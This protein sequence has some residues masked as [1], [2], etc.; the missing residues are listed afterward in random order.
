MAISRK[1][2]TKEQALSRLTSL[3]GRSEQC[4]YEVIK[5]MKG[6]GL[7]PTHIK[8]VLDYLKENRF[9]DDVRYARS[10]I[11]DKARFSSWGPYKIK[12]EL[13]KRRIPSKIIDPALKEVDPS[14]WKEAVLKCGRNKSRS[15]DLRGEEGYEN[16]RKLYSY[17]ISRG[18]SSALSSKVVRL[19]QKEQEEKDESLD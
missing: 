3:C 6:W 2:L 8:D 12:L 4:E 7:S 18:F 19:M 15:L 1:V 14:I 5:K 10:Y 11:N 17:L 9:V 16:S 13:I